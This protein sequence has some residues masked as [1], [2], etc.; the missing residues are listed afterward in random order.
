MIN[1]EYYV[2]THNVLACKQLRRFYE[3]VEESSY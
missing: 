2:L 3:V 1:P